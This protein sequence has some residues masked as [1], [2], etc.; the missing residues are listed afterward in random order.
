MDRVILAGARRIEPREGNRYRTIVRLG[1]SGRRRAGLRSEERDC[2]AIIERAGRLLHQG[3]TLCVRDGADVLCA[4]SKSAAR[5]ACKSRAHSSLA[6]LP[7]LG[8]SGEIVGRR[9]LFL[10]LHW[11]ASRFA[12]IRGWNTQDKCIQLML[13]NMR[14]RN[15]KW[16]GNK[17]RQFEK[18]CS[19]RYTP[20]G[21]PDFNERA[22]ERFRQGGRSFL[23]EEKINNDLGI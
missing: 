14:A 9:V 20:V 21:E 6:R 1:F 23:F 15:P 8:Y 11:N 16:R 13:G 22:G 17:A 4:V 10:R 12:H 2:K 19:S 3:Y 7:R 18:N 5:V